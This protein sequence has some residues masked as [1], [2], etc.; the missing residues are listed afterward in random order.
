[1]V[2]SVAGLLHA[3]S[4]AVASRFA[5]CA[6]QGELSAFSRASS[7]HC[8][9]CLK[10]AEGDAALIRCAMFR[11]AATMLDFRPADGQRVEVRG[12][13]TVYEPRGELQFVVEW[14]RPAGAGALLEQFARLKARLQAEGLFDPARKRALPAFPRRIGVVTSLDAAAL[15]DV[16]S[17]LARRAPHVAVVVYPSVVQ[18]GEA[19]AS[20][21][22]ALD[23]AA[24]RAEVDAI[25]LC[26]GGGSLEDLWAFNDERVVRAVAGSPI[27][28]VCGV[29]HETDVTL[30]DFAADVRAPTPTA[31]AELA[32][33]AQADAL[34]ALDALAVRLVR[35]L[36]HALDA[37]EQ[38]L[39]AAGWR[40]A[41]PTLALRR[42]A[43]ALAL[44]AQ[45]LAGA[46]RQAVPAR[47]GRL[48]QLA[49]RLVR[50]ASA[51]LSPQAARLD[52]LER[53][54]ARSAHVCLAGRQ[55]RLDALE[56]RLLGLDPRRVLRRGYA[57]LADGE[58]RPVQTVA[59]M[60]VGQRL[61]V[62]LADG[63]AGVEVTRVTP[64]EPG[65]DPHA[66][67]A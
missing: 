5:V 65:A 28:V 39:D 14:M 63:S 46:A 1:V 24:R 2:W 42:Q 51:R 33:V 16:L 9:F 57:W 8:Y 36:R 30:A 13:L 54:L 40:L 61:D 45:R 44:A 7:G 50:A 48:A 18:G 38:R 53:R 59:Q 62:M 55:A 47:G 27:A 19:P 52:T 64:A 23:V 25:V 56:A 15:H 31:A 10:D 58:G 43:A 22:R 11:R 34:A 29:G 26:R 37:H 41:R 67:R 60:R 49:G 3:V 32:T 4:D 66:S 17:S 20:L 21:V 12:R 35:R 6:V